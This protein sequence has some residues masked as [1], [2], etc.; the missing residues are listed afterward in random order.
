MRIIAREHRHT[1]LLSPPDTAK[2]VT[3]ATSA[4]ATLRGDT[5][6]IE[7]QVVSIRTGAS[8]TRPVVAG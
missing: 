5:G 4:E 1:S 7:V 3:V 8:C 6:A 2:S